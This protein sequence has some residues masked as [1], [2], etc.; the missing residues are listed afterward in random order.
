MTRSRVAVSV[1]S[2]LLFLIPAHANGETVAINFTN[3]SDVSCGTRW[4]EA[5]VNFEIA[6][7]P[8]NHSCTGSC[9]PGV[10]LTGLQLFP[11]GLT[12]DMSGAGG[13]MDIE[14]DIIESDPSL[15]ATAWLYYDDGQTT[16]DGASSTATGAGT[17]SLNAEGLAVDF[18]EVY[19]CECTIVEIRLIGDVI[20]SAS[21]FSWGTMKAR[22]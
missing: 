11:S 8:A 6:H 17:L 2:A 20:V 16:V 5:G 4:Q 14:I 18:L 10:D 21:G 7:I 15:T 1:A 12:M 13:V 9:L 22:Y 3:L 19:C